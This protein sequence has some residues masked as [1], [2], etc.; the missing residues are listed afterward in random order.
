[1]RN[2]IFRV[3]ILIIMFSFL[4]ACQQ[5][6]NNLDIKKTIKRGMTIDGLKEGVWIEYDDKGNVK[7]IKNYKK[8]KLHG[9]HVSFYPDGSIYSFGSYTNGVSNGPSVLFFSNQNINVQDNYKNGLLNGFSNL[10]GKNGNL[11]QSFFYLNNKKEG[12]QYYLDEFT[13]DTIKIERYKKGIKS[14]N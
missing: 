3:L 4:Y 13:G 11:K 1:M 9:G 6:K 2:K 7:R 8:G 5:K 10:Y 12:Y 14:K